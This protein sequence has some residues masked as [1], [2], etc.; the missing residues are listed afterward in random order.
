MVNSEC[1]TED[2]C[3]KLRK[4]LGENAFTATRGISHARLEDLPVR[5]EG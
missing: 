4:W 2:F 5:L 1:W 3:A